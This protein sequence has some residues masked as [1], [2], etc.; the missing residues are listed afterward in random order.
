MT[1]S[2]KNSRAHAKAGTSVMPFGAGAG[3]RRELMACH[4]ER[5][6]PVMTVI[7]WGSKGRLVRHG[8]ESCCRVLALDSSFHYSCYE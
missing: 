8:F 7:T 3:L 5:V 4:S 1:S 2:H 6:D